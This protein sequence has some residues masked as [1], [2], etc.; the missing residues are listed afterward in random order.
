M[1]CPERNK[2][3]GTCIRHFTCL[4]MPARNAA[5][6]PSCMPDM[7]SDYKD[8]HTESDCPPCHVQSA[9]IECQT[10][11]GHRKHRTMP[12]ACITH[13]KG[14]EGPQKHAHSMQ[15]TPQI[16][17]GVL[18]HIEAPDQCRLP[19]W[20]GCRMHPDSACQGSQGSSHAETHMHSATCNLQCTAMC[21]L[22]GQ[23]VNHGE[24]MAMG[25][26]RA[27]VIVSCVHRAEGPGIPKWVRA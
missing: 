10:R 16:K 17:Q 24:G 4:Q 27:C 1:K 9:S 15:Q 26:C 22:Q 5:V 14:D 18:Y 23:D 12:A 7:P 20:C 13:G 21:A 6:V 2:F 25:S 11:H 3:S 19:R 8:P